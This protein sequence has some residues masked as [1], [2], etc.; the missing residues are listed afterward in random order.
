MFFLLCCL[1]NIST[2]AMSEA[3]PLSSSY[4]SGMFYSVLLDP[5]HINH[6]RCCYTTS[7]RLRPAPYS[8]PSLRL[9]VVF[10][11]VLRGFSGRPEDGL[12]R[13]EHVTLVLHCSPESTISGHFIQQDVVEERVNAST[14]THRIIADRGYFVMKRA[15]RP[16]NCSWYKYM[17][18]PQK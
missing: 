3:E 10:C 8:Q 9:P 16:F 11:K 17:S 12:F 4:G 5:P 14:H 6:P 15:L 18:A 1:G 13:P 2:G 7:F